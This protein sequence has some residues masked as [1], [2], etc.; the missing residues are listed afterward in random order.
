MKNITE[1]VLKFI[2]NLDYKEKTSPNTVIAYAGDLHQ[3]FQDVL[4]G[5]IQGPAMNTAGDYCYLI[6]DDFT[7]HAC[8]LTKKNLEEITRNYLFSLNGV[9]T[10]TRARKIA[11]LRKFFGFLKT[12][13]IVDEIPRMLVTPKTVEKI[14]NFLSIDEAMAVLKTF[15]ASS[16]APRDIHSKVLFL[17]LYGT[18]LR[19]SEACELTWEDVNLT[20]REL[21]IHGKGNKMRVIS[22]PI[23]VQLN[24]AS[25]RSTQSKKYIW[26]DKALNTRTAYN[27]ISQIGRKAGLSKPIHPHALRHSYATHLMNDG[28]DLRVIQE[29]LGHA[30]LVATEKY[31]HVSM[32]QLS[33]TMENFHPLSRKVGS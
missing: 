22:M 11:T 12:E 32:D 3:V 26:G 1:L 17:L 13:K 14:P 33:R 2:E 21:R 27:Y 25:L 23:L 15:S 20:K 30:S 10:S 6:N 5:I 4:P 16:L 29:M 24:L 19:V 9:E 8:P 18:G 28:A 7:P 31:T